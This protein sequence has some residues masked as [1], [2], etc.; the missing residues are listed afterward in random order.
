MT[1]KKISYSVLQDVLHY[2][3]A[4]K[5]IETLQL[6]FYALL[7]ARHDRRTTEVALGGGV[8]GD[9]AGFA[10]ASYQRGVDFIQVPTTL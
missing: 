5:K 4:H 10:A 6:I 8:I 2:A 3:Y 1:K 9:M 7:T